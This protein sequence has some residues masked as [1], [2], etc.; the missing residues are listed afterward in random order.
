MD[1]LDV[2]DEED[3]GRRDLDRL[4]EERDLLE[5]LDLLDDRDL[6][7]DRDFDLD[8]DARRLRLDLLE[9]SGDLD[10]DRRLLGDRAGDQTNGLCSG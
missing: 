2:D 3:V 1:E 4:L 6:L 10:H 5:D 9:P 8:F 7:E